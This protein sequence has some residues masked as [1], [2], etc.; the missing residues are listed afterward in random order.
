MN[1]KPP[2]VQIIAGRWKRRRLGVPED[3]RPTSGRA[4]EALFSILQKR[5]PGAR[6]LDLYAGS[7]AFGLEAVSRGAALAVLVEKDGR[8][9]RDNLARLPPPREEIEIVAAHAD[10]ALETFLRAGRRFDIVFADPPYGT[11]PEALRARAEGVLEPGGLFVYQGDRGGEGAPAL[12]GLHCVERRE[13]GRNV[14][15]FFSADPAA[16]PSKAP[17]DLPGSRTKRS[18]PGPL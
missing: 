17:P 13:Y 9:L 3:A 12:A 7:G 14:F 11:S 6:V 15:F 1:R 4:R 8:M 10:A 5:I 2:S 18:E 16:R